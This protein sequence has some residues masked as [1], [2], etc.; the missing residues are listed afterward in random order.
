MLRRVLAVLAA[1]VLTAS[2]TV[3]AAP[4]DA[5]TAQWLRTSG[6][7]IQVA[8]TGATF[9]VKATSWFGMETDTCAP[10]GL[11]SISLK[12]GMAQ[13]AGMGFNTIRLPF[14]NECLTR[15]TANSVNQALNPTLATAS[16]LKIMD[17]V[18]ATARAYGIRVILDRHRP[19]TDAQSELWYTPQYS[20]KRWISDWKMLAQR[21][22][23]NSTVIGV[24][25]HNEPRG[26][27]CWG[28][29]DRSRDWQAAAVRAGNAVLDVNPHLLVI[30][31]GVQNGPDGSATWWGGNLRG[32]AKKPVT[33]KVKNRVVYSPHEY[34]SSISDQ[35]WFHNTNYPANL[36]G[37]WESNWGYIAS[38]KIAPVLI[39]EFGTKLQ[40]SSD[41][42]WLAKLVGYIKDR[43]LGWAYWSFNPNS[44]DT[45][46]L[47][48]DDWVTRDKDKLAALKPILTPKK[49]AYPA[50][51]APAPAPLP[52]QPSPQPSQPGNTPPP[53]VGQSSSASS[54]GVSATLTVSSAWPGKYQ[55]ALALT[56]SSSAK[57]KAWTASWASPGATGADSAWGMACRVTKPGT[58]SA[59]VACSG[60]EWGVANLS[61]GARV[62]VGAILNA[63][64]P[65]AKPVLSL[66]VTR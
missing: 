1:V 34:P 27:A 5:A 21:Y 4:A 45:G 8:A 19:G 10:H 38:K 32:V 13:I 33:L 53:A 31:E 18:I 9:T 12:Q 22:R 35:P 29:G 2:L 65:P 17:A 6:A 25:L 59:R 63:S 48:K 64:K 50:A 62:E 39:G 57:V 40:T 15:K 20:E 47:L 58:A 26:A 42:K 7:K 23:N 51:P 43:G 60:I 37:V 11:W 36:P 14:A 55:V 49:V 66:S 44:G 3:P 52:P 41:K 56:A 61:Q 16:P 24:D 54:N 46:G 30:V 28:C